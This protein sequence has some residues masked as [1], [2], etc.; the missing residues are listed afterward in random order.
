MAKSGWQAGDGL[1]ANRQGTT[2][3]VRMKFKDDSLGESRVILSMADVS[4]ASRAYRASLEEIHDFHQGRAVVNFSG[5][6]Y[7]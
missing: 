1:G 5:P 6:I 7:S 2:E 3:H 4:F